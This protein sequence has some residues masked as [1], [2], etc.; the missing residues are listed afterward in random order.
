[1]SAFSSN[2][3]HR[4]CFQTKVLTD[5]SGHVIGGNTERFGY[6]IPRGETAMTLSLVFVVREALFRY[7]IIYVM[8]H[9]MRIHFC[10]SIFLYVLL[11]CPYF[12][13]EKEMS[14]HSSTLA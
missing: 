4:S 5:M 14:T 8:Q 1:M 10:S 2:K 9:M 11:L 6:Y 7:F 12:A 13:T 3:I